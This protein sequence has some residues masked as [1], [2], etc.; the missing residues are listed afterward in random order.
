LKKILFSFKIVGS[1]IVGSKIVGS[2]I[3]GLRTPITSM[4]QH[5]III[6]SFR[7]GVLNL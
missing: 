2:K 5:K 1:K 3:V 6:L 7:S 4:L